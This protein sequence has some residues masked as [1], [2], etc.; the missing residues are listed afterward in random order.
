MHVLLMFIAT[1]IEC[2]SDIFRHEFF[3]Y[4][5]FHFTDMYTLQLYQRYHP[6]VHNFGI[7][8]VAYTTLNPGAV[9]MDYPS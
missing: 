7:H 4:A 5:F 1:S 8:Q 3:F 9:M 2:Q 6:G